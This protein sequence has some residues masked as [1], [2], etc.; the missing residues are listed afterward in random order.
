MSRL[1]YVFVSLSTIA[2]MIFAFSESPFFP[3]IHSA[4]RDGSVFA[5]GF[6]P[7]HPRD[8]KER[9][10]NFHYRN[11]H[12]NYNSWTD[13]STGSVHRLADEV[14]AFAPACVPASPCILYT[15]TQC[16]GVVDGNGVCS[17]DI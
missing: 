6:D 13:P 14:C 2:K 15:S 16:A 3:G 17:V 5:H 11:T 9:V 8:V 10:V 7:L 4:S 12:K 1:S